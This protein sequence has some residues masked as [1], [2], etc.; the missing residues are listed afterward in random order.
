MGMSIEQFPTCENQQNLEEL[1]REAIKKKIAERLDQSFTSRLSEYLTGMKPDNPAMLGR[2]ELDQN[3]IR[4]KYHLPSSDLPLPEFEQ[5]LRQIAKELN[6]EIKSKS[7]CGK[8]FEENT[9]AGAVHF[10]DDKQ[11]G[12]NID[13]KDLRS[14]ANSLNT[15]EHELIHAIQQQESPSAP[16]ELK[17]YEAY[18]ANA[19]LDYLKKNPEAVEEILFGFFIN[20]SVNI[21]YNLESKRRGEKLSP[22]WDNAEFFLKIDGIDPSEIGYKL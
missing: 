21:Y 19:N 13:R 11:I 8:F 3:I 2:L 10:G 18:V 5:A 6:I 15:L 12:V 14:Y 1:K 17:E 22:K 20:S 7:D 4:A 16:I 9:G